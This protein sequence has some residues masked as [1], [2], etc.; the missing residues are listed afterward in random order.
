VHS[1]KKFAT[2][3]AESSYLLKH[4]AGIHMREILGIMRAFRSH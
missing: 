1:R 4:P 3:S 2:G